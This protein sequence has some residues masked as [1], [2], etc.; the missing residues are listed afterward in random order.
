MNK[1]PRQPAILRS[2]KDELAR[3]LADNGLNPGD[4]KWIDE[5][6]TEWDVPRGIQLE[7][8]VHEGTDYYFLPGVQ[9][10][11]TRY[12]ERTVHFVEF[13]PGDTSAVYSNS[14]ERRW[15]DQLAEAERWMANL[16]RELAT[17]DYWS[18][19][20]ERIA[21]P[22]PKD[23][24]SVFSAQEQDAIR[25][26]F[27]R[28]ETK[29]AEMYGEQREAIHDEISLLLEESRRQGRQA[30]LRTVFG[31]MFTIA[32]ICGMDASDV[33]TMV[34]FTLAALSEASNTLSDLVDKG[35]RMLPSGDTSE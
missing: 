18:L 15:P 7:R 27:E 25:T 33:G 13:A 29:L 23:D 3:L 32:K 20:S 34:N 21:L 24:N 2:Q 31:A 30:W 26:G 16:K 22:Q 14:S 10:G 11:G 28:I 35:I 17:P 6:R 1:R 5:N 4:F 8:L 9:V 19:L 12:D